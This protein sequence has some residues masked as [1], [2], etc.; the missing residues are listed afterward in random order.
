ME[1]KKEK[2]SSEIQQNFKTNYR[3]TYEASPFF[4]FSNASSITANGGV[5]LIDI[6]EQN[7]SSQKYLPLTN[8]RIA[9]N[10]TENI[11]LYPNQQSEGIVIP[12]GTI[13]SFD[14]KTVPAL[15]SIKV[16]NLHASNDISANEIRIAVWKE[17]IE[18]DTAFKN[19]HK[20]FFRFLGSAK[21]PTQKSI[22][23]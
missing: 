8:L 7:T 4:D 22:T 20:A 12:A 11:A 16:E 17:A 15:I 3:R 1:T 5:W 9:N 2:A 18:F 19:M 23:D 13:L 10:S 14:R 6:G 21:N